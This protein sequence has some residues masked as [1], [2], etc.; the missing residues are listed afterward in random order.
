MDKLE[1]G[2]NG[3]HLPLMLFTSF[4]EFVH[5]QHVKIS[6]LFLLSKKKKEEGEED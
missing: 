2:R 6:T 1:E 5:T 3:W 4:P